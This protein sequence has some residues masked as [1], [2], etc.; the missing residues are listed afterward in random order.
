MIKNMSLCD[1]EYESLWSR[2]KVY[3]QVL[4]LCD[5]DLS[6]CDRDLRSMVKF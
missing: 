2:F 6:L 5:Q 1:Q 4:S 3:D